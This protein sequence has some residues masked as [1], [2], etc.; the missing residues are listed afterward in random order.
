MHNGG[1][2]D[3][4]AVIFVS[5][6]G[7]QQLASLQGTQEKENYGQGQRNHKQRIPKS[8]KRAIGGLLL[9]DNF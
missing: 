1:E 5:K 8:G 9:I 2:V 7:N 4:P 3:A 6:C